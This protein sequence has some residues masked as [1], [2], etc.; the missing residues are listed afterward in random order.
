MLPEHATMATYARTAVNP[1][2]ALCQGLAYK[3]AGPA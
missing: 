3:P 2:E 1:F